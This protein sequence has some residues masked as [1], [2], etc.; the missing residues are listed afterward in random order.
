MMVGPDEQ[1]P[2]VTRI[3]LDVKETEPILESELAQF[4]S[5]CEELEK[6]KE[7]N[8]SDI[9]KKQSPSASNQAVSIQ[10]SPLSSYPE[11]CRS[12][13]CFGSGARG[14]VSFQGK[15]ARSDIS[16]WSQVQ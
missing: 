4:K 8:D 2:G 14:E 16:F 3:V 9:E 7:M 5:S 13:I 12:N 10:N 15:D 11:G 1:K 6:S